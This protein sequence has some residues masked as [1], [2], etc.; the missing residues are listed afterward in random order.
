[1]KNK[2]LTLYSAKTVA[3]FFII[4]LHFKDLGEYTSIVKQI[5]RFAVPLFFMISGYFTVYKDKKKCDEK[6]N[7]RL[8]K[9]DILTAK[10]VVFYSAISVIN[11]LIAG[12]IKDNFALAPKSVFNFLLFNKMPFYNMPHL[13]YLFALIYTLALVK[14]VNKYDLYKEGYVFS[15]II[16][17]A[18]FI[19]E[20]LDSSFLLQTEEFYFRNAWTLGFPF[21]MLGHFIKTNEEKLELTNLK[22][23]IS[24]IA[25]TLLTILLFVIEK[26]IMDAKNHPIFISSILLDI[27]I[28][29]IAINKKNIN[30][31]SGIGEKD[32]KNIYIIHYAIT[33]MILHYQSTLN[34]A[35]PLLPIIVFVL[36]YIVSVIYRIIKERMTRRT[37]HNGKSKKN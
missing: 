2:N 14:I 27:F 12:S 33:L 28:F 24:I 23:I 18:V 5:A 22:L 30:F 15:L 3:C 31:F 11:C 6:L 1:M 20:I 37:E 34:I 19:F 32:S 13:W 21:F 25:L 7:E 17:V 4:A 26:N 29:L 16:I 9:I 10:A 36:A 8:K 35:K